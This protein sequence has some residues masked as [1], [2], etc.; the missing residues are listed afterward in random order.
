MAEE[1]D[2]RKTWAELQNGISLSK[3]ARRHGVS[4]FSLARKLRRDNENQY[5]RAM[6]KKSDNMEKNVDLQTVWTELE[7]GTSLIRAARKHEISHPVLRK[8]LRRDDEKRYARIMWSRNAKDPA[9]KKSRALSAMSANLIKEFEDVASL[10]ELQRKY[11]VYKR[12]LQR[13]FINIYGE[14]YKELIKPRRVGFGSKTGPG[15][16]ELETEIIKLL[17]ENGIHF[18]LHKKLTAQGHRYIADFLIGDHT[19]IEVTGMTTRRYWEHNS[20][21]LRTYMGSRYRVILVMERRKLKSVQ[22]YFPEPSDRFVV[23][24]YEDL[25]SD[26]VRFLGII[27]GGE[28][29]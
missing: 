26:F 11:G 7:N 25:R 4:R 10:G 15:D 6:K 19:I 9:V 24:E 12:T 5:A 13:R 27:T 14:V 20:R 18:V 29:T 1:I 23:I 16:S 8:K 28:S 22:H 3:I 21:K 17:E 2:L